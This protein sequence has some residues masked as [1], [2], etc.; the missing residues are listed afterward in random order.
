MPSGGVAGKYNQI[1]FFVDL[2]FHN[3]RTTP[4]GGERKKEKKKNNPKIPLVPMGVLAQGSA[5]FCW[6][7]YLR[8]GG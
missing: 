4:C 2:Q 5:E 7:T 3:P 8:G 6:R 1:L